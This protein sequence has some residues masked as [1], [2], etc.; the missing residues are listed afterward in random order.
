MPPGAITILSN[1]RNRFHTS[2]V[3]I[4]CPA[5]MTQ[6]RDPDYW[7][8]QA[9]E[10]R[11]AAADMTDPASKRTLERIATSYECWPGKLRS[12]RRPLATFNNTVI[13]R[14]DVAPPPERRHGDQRHAAVPDAPKLGEM[15]VYSARGVTQIWLDPGSS[16]RSAEPFAAA[17]RI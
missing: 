10:A 14:I 4:L 6:K 1:T 15:E 12:P 8:A 9:A 13:N 17:G 11:A 3:A 7:R 2:L 5:P 16:S